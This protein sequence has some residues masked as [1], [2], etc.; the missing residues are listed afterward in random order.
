MRDNIYSIDNDLIDIQRFIELLVL[1]LPFSSFLLSSSALLSNRCES[2]SRLLLS[3]RYRRSSFTVENSRTQ[4]I[5]VMMR[6]TLYI[7]FASLNN[8]VLNLDASSIL[9]RHQCETW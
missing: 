2:Q 4:C 5:S 7:S 9:V 1:N 6:N 8:K 3:P